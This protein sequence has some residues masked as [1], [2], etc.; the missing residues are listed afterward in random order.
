MGLREFVFE[1]RY[2][3]GADPLADTFI[4]HPDLMSQSVTCTVTDRNVWHLEQFTGPGAALEELDVLF[5]ELTACD[6]GVSG[7]R[8]YENWQF[9]QLSKD[10]GTRTVCAYGID[11]ETSKSIPHLAAVY[12]AD[13]LLYNTR[14]RGDR[15]RWRILMP[16]EVS[17][18]NFYET[19]RA[20]LPDE[21]DVDF[22]HVGDPDDW[23]EDTVTLT[24]LSHEQ[25]R[26]L[27]AAVTHG[28]YEQ[29]REITAAE[30]ASKL[31]VPQSTLQYR[32]NRAEAWLA[33]EFVSELPS[34]PSGAGE[35]GVTATD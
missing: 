26:V 18:E 15:C 34:Q 30:L 28:Y 23:G 7:D 31:D 24:D 2:S 8:Q 29:P 9:K 5:D 10:V 16:Q 4:A 21:L 27:E 12:V 35:P 1:V 25:R 17:V 14:R 22:D 33:T 32:L 11:V 13:G 20:T 3:A 19:V 6:T